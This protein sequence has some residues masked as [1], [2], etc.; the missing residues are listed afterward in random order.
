MTTRAHAPKL[1]KPSIPLRTSLRQFEKRQLILPFSEKRAT[2]PLNLQHFSGKCSPAPPGRD[3]CTLWALL[4]SLGLFCSSLE[5]PEVTLGSLLGLLASLLGSLLCP[6]GLPRVA[7]GP[8]GAP[9]GAFLGGPRRP[10]G[11]TCV[12]VGAPKRRKTQ[13][14]LLN[15]R[16][17]GSG[18]P[19]TGMCGG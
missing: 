8:P 15:T 4:G 19:A 7:L 5:L 9:L 17:C 6:C 16:G 18:W 1:L 12:S 10:D 14:N 3:S 13:N 2:F 11:S